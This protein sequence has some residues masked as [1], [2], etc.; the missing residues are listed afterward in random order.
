MKKIV[1]LLLAILA[2]GVVSASAQNVSGVVRDQNGEPLIVAS[3][4]WEGTLIG[5]ATDVDG[6]YTIYRV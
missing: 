6:A 4:Y 2:G 1:T 3:L 5:T